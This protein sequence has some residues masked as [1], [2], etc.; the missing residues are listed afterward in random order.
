MH[1]FVGI[2]DSRG[3]MVWS[4]YFMSVCFSTRYLEKRCS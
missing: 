4:A 3:T 2:S 1:V